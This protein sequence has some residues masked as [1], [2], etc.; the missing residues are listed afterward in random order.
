MYT[1]KRIVDKN[2]KSDITNNILRKLPE[3]FG[4]EESIKEYVNEVKD[5]DFFAAYDSNLP[6]GFI[7]IKDNNK[8]TAEIYVIGILKEYQNHGIGNKLLENIQEILR[9]N[10]Y[11]FLMVKTLGESHPDIYYKRTRE[12][13]TKTGFYPLEEI[14]Q[15]WGKDN[16]CL[17]MVKTIS[18]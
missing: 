16:P 5:T 12:F 9:D 4:I 18:E 6:V 8:F 3:W 1:L 10:K 17:I 11:K 2:E 13:Y 15:I 14:N 7:S